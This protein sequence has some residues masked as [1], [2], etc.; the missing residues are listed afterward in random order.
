M[1]GIIAPCL[2]TLRSRR[3]SDTPRPIDCRLVPGRRPARDFP[4]VACAARDRN[5]VAHA[6]VTISSHIQR[7][8]AIPFS[9]ACTHG[10]SWLFT[11]ARANHS[12]LRLLTTAPA[13][14]CGG[15]YHYRDTSGYSQHATDRITPLALR[16]PSALHLTSHLARLG[17]AD[18][19]RSWSNGHHRPAPEQNSENVNGVAKNPRPLA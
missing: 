4:D 7:Q 10:Y 6:L 3:Q 13:T 8:S 5:H 18:S 12:Y 1:D 9:G 11:A 16:H 2:L 17:I 14:Y 19:G 15:A